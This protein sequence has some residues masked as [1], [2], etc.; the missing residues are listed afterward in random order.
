M[1]IIIVSDSL[2]SRPWVDHFG[3][4]LS[5]AARRG[6]KSL[7]DNLKM[8]RK[9]NS[10]EGIRYGSIP[11]SD[12][13]KAPLYHKSDIAL[14]AYLIQNMLKEVGVF[15]EDFTPMMYK[16]IFEDMTVEEVVAKNVQE[17][18]I[19]EPDVTNGS[20]CGECGANSVIKKDGC[21]FCTSC[22]WQGSCG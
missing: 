8:S 14:I 11:K 13:G 7:A 4:S 19:P 16:D 6:I 2:A 21:K 18:V 3:R 9:S 22:G 1:G 20:P 12:G 15:K 10:N 5:L 17:E